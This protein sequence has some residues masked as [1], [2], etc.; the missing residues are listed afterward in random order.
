MTWSVLLTT[1]R[2]GSIR[3]TLSV[4]VIHIEAILGLTLAV[5]IWDGIQVGQQVGCGAV[6]AG[7]AIAV[8][9]GQERAVVAVLGV[10]SARV[11]LGAA[12]AEGRTVGFLIGA[13]VAC[14][15]QCVSWV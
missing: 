2:T 9:D 15:G 14:G 3:R 1:S 13:D 10:R 12:A 11:F 5:D 7:A 8:R 6:G 4:L